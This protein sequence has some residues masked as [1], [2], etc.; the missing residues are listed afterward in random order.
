MGLE[1]P[2]D[3]DGYLTALDAFAADLQAKV[4]NDLCYDFARDIGVDFWTSAWMPI[5][6]QHCISSAAVSDPPPVVATQNRFDVLSAAA[7][8]LRLRE[9]QAFFG[10]ADTTPREDG[11]SASTAAPVFPSDSLPSS[12]P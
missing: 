11:M 10:L 2:S 3:L 6:S 8:V 9:V 7:D 1:V 12:P 4:N 5:P